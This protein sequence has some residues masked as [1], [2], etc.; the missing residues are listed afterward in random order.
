MN[1]V[2][3]SACVIIPPKELWD[4]IQT[5][6]QIYDRH[7]HRW[8]PHITLLYPFRSK[9]EFDDLE[10]SFIKKC[11][12]IHSFEIILRKLRYF[13]HRHQNYTIWLDPEPTNSITQLQAELLKIV[14]DCDDVNKYKNGFT[15]HLSVGQ[16][17]GKEKLDH[18]IETLQNSW[19][20]LRFLLNSVYF[21]SRENNK[22]S[23]FE[24]I[25][26]ILLKV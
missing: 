11:S 4:P 21:I 14:P 2:H 12:E 5:I 18:I 22:F 17:K 6:R 9:A 16:V 1:K 13:R 19:K 8:M 20:D 24:I 3:T 15:P 23:R 26:E 7:I 25:K 10:K